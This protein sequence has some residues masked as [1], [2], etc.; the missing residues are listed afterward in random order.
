[1]SYIGYRDDCCDISNTTTTRN[2]FKLKQQIIKINDGEVG[3]GVN[4]GI[5]GIQVER[6][7]LPD[8]LIQWNEEIDSWEYGIDGNLRIFGKSAVKINTS[9]LTKPFHVYLVDT[10]ATEVTV[11]LPQNPNMG[12]EIEFIDLKGKF[13]VHSCII[14]SNGSKILGTTEDAILDVKYANVKFVYIDLV[15]GWI[16]APSNPITLSNV[17]VN[18]DLTPELLET[19]QNY[20]SNYIESNF[21]TTIENTVNVYI[22]NNIDVIS[23]ALAGPGL[24]KNSSGK[25]EVD[26]G[27]GLSIVNNKLTV[28]GGTGGAPS[29][30]VIE[31]KSSNFT[32][33]KF[34]HYAIDTTSNIVNITL[35]INP[36]S[37]DWFGIL[38]INSNFGTNKVSISSFNGNNLDLD[39]NDIHIRCA[40]VNNKWLILNDTISYS[41]SGNSSNATPSSI[42]IKTTNFSPESNIYYALDTTSN[43]ITITLPSTPITGDWFGIL[44]LKGNFGTNKVT[45]LNSGNS[46]FNVVGNLELDL[47]NINVRLLFINGNWIILND[48]ISYSLTSGENSSSQRNVQSVTSSF[49][50]TPNTYYLINALSPLSITL[51]SNPVNGDWFKITDSSRLFESNVVTLLNNGLS[52]IANSTDNLIFDVRGMSAELIFDNG[53]WNILH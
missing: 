38:D 13:D 12:D 24:F 11:L 32:A 27:T 48:T 16:L 9:T 19:I 45:V 42:E 20:I 2:I 39:L 30:L 31:N 33:E 26:I 41:I 4:A 15:S 21:D 23:T 53:N 1:M 36:I 8:A 25:L 3:S 6:G 46:I 34:K 47:N 22:E 28:T 40:F 35:P 51:P 52:T 43:Q 18:F 37:G 10:S 5:A 49:S 50:A 7:Q 29:N 14:L 44:D 17:D